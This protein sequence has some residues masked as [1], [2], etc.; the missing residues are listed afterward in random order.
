MFNFKF[1][2][3]FLSSLKINIQLSWES[4]KPNTGCRCSHH[5]RPFT[6]RGTLIL[7]QATP[8][9]WR[10]CLWV[11]CV[12]F[13]GEASRVLSCTSHRGSRLNKD[14]AALDPLWQLLPFIHQGQS[15]PPSSFSTVPLRS[16]PP[17]CSSGW[18]LD[19][20]SHDLTTSLQLLTTVFNARSDSSQRSLSAPLPNFSLK[21]KPRLTWIFLLALLPESC[22]APDKLVKVSDPWL[23]YL[24]TGIT[25]PLSQGIWWGSNE[26]AQVTNLV[27]SLLSF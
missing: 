17:P 1:Q 16:I 18:G 9:K 26:L 23:C 15:I 4:Y 21:W 22:V 11:G 2:R 13:L 20:V 12:H 19:V 10:W 5:F 14:V 3:S 6:G 27:H 24:K 7:N 8:P 25:I